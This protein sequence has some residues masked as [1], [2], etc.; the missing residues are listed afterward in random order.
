MSGI[1]NLDGRIAVVT[2]G[3]SGI[4]RGIAEELLSCG[5]KVVIADIETVKLEATAAEIGA[6]GI[7]TDVEL[8]IGGLHDVEVND[9]TAEYKGV[10]RWLEPR[11]VGRLV[12]ESIR[13]GRLYV[14]THPEMFDSIRPRHQ[15]IAA[16]YSS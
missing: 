7:R 11:D 12:A 13:D 1:A 4:G 8:P 15:A 10:A 5:V 6:V 9:I 14:V 16:A 3:A 2:G